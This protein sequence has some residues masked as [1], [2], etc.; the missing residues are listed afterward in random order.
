MGNYILAGASGRIATETAAKLQAGGHHVIGISTKPQQFAYNEFYQVGGYRQEELPVIT[1][2][3]SGLVYFPGSITLKP[4]RSVTENDIMNDMQINCL[5][6][7]AFVKQ[8][9]SNVKQSGNGSVVLMSSVAAQ[10]GMPYHASIAMAKGAI[11]SL[12]RSLAAELAPSVRVNCV[13]PSLTD[14]PLA[15]R[16]LNSPDKIEAAQKRNPMKKVG[17][18]AVV[19]AAVAYLLSD[20][21]SWTTGQVLAVDGGMGALVV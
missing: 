9:L 20:D 13:A 3:V 14:T 15:E 1:V 12:V 11:E 6:A 16:L 17:D 5:G 8:Y 4:F 10:R 19:A 7:V 2:P 21:A 18:P